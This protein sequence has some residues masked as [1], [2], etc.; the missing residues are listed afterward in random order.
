MLAAK[1][2]R[3][4]AAALIAAT[5][6]WA[7][8]PRHGGT[9][10]VALG[11]DPAGLNP[12][13]TVGVPDVFTGCILY[14]GLVRFAEGFKIVPSLAR[15]WTISP[16]ALTYTFQLNKASCFMSP[17][18]NLPNKPSPPTEKKSACNLACWS[19]V[20]S[21]LIDVHCLSGSSSH[22]PCP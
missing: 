5:S 18:S 17:L 11:S 6:A 4:A 8:E 3:L 20:A 19:T 10:V 7:Q 22:T 1:L 13:I 9:A 15:S 21:C 16:D 12:D 14:D 2:A